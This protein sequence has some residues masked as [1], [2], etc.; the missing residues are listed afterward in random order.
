MTADAVVKSFTDQLAAAG[1]HRVWERAP[2]VMASSVP[3]ATG[4]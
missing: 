3:P 1:L 2:S 4:S